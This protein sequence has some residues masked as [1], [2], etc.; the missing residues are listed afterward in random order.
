MPKHTESITFQASNNITSAGTTYGDA[1]R[2]D[3]FD[4]LNLFLY[5]SVQG[6]FTDET[7]N[8][9]VQ[10]K[11]P[12]GNYIDLTDAA[13]TEITNATAVDPYLAE[14]IAIVAFG[15]VVRL[16][17]V[18]TTSGGSVDYTFTVKGYGKGNF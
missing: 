13:F 17:Y 1:I 7:L 12:D 8:V 16:K 10:I 3:K 4:E 2:V 9:N 15:S 18:T 14:H 6:S 11:D 5:I